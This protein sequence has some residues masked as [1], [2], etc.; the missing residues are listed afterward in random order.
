MKRAIALLSFTVILS[1]AALSQVPSGL[2]SHFFADCCGSCCSQGDCASC[3]KGEC[4]KAG[5]DHS[6]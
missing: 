1:V 6:K 3:C 2:K 4:A 5:C